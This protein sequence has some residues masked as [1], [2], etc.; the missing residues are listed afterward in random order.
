MSGDITISEWQRP[1]PALVRQFEAF[2]VAVIGDALGRLDI[3][4]GGIAPIW[5]GAHCVGSALPIYT[6]AGDNL[7]VNG[8]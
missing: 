3:M 2:P 8:H 6:T 7:A 1:D 5:D 4:D